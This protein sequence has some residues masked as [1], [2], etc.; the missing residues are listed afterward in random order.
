MSMAETVAIEEA[1]KPAAAWDLM[2]VVAI[3]QAGFPMEL[4]SP[5]GDSASQ[6]EAHV[7][8][9][10][11]DRL[12][13]IIT[14]LK[15]QIKSIEHPAKS[16]I[17][18]ALGTRKPFGN[19]ALA[20]IDE[21]DWRD[22]REALLEYHHSAQKLLDRWKQFEV[23]LASRLNDSR[24]IVVEEFKLKSE[25]RAILMLSNDANYGPFSD[26]L[27][28]FNDPKGGHF[29][30]MADMLTLYLQ[31]VTTKNDT[32][33]HF[34]PINFGRVDHSQKGINWSSQVNLDR[35]SYCSHWAAEQIA[36]M[37]S[38]V[39]D[40]NLHIQPRR[41]PLS[42]CDDGR[43]DLYAFTTADGLMSDWRFARVVSQP[44]APEAQW[45]WERCDGKATI[46]EL[47]HGWDN[48]WITNGTSRASFDEAFEF[49]TKGGFVV[50]HFEIPA[51]V[52]EPLENLLAQLNISNTPSSREVIRKIADLNTKIRTFA[53]C[54]PSE[55]EE[56]LSH[57][58]DEFKSL[59]GCEPN[60]H[61]GIHQADRSVLFEEAHGLLEDLTIG[62][63]ISQFV[64]EELAPAFE[65]T[66]AKSR[67][68]MELELEVLTDWF[69]RRFGSGRQ[70]GLH[71]FYGAFF[72][73]RDHLRG[74]T[75]KVENQL[76]CFDRS[77]TDMLLGSYS[78]SDEEIVVPTIDLRRFVATLPKW[79]AAVCNPDILFAAKSQS[80]LAQGKFLAV[81][82]ECHAIREVLSHSSFA[83]MAEE[84]V[85]EFGREVISGY[86]GLL[87]GDEYLV[88]IIRGHPDKTACQLELPIRDLEVFGRS[89]K[90]RGNVLQPHQVHLILQD[91]G[92]ELRARSIEG[93]I[94]LLAPPAG[95]PSIHDDP[96]SVFAFPRNFSG[97]NVEAGH[98]D[99]IP[100]IRTG[101]VVLHRRTWRI[102]KEQL[103]GI[104][105]RGD[106]VNHGDAAE[107]LS[108]QRLT[109]RLGL[110]RHVFAKVPGEPKP[111][112]VDWL[113]P[114]LVR[115]LFRLARDTAGQIE[116]SEM[117]PGPEHLW[118]DIQGRRYTSELRCAVF[119]R[120]GRN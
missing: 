84:R 92:L 39:P 4:L 45:L 38:S 87:E 99:Y 77:M 96:L 120:K 3:R 80:E 7:L 61:P 119:N 20:A 66:L 112:Y 89:P 9:S 31:R 32:H 116:F 109:A 102:P 24:K 51:G 36:M 28:K 58:K 70:V 22:A 60:R 30:R 104:T 25:L 6:D 82:G 117:L 100:R 105:V 15:L 63:D 50:S 85:P 5:L 10:L 65:L 83:K 17:S 78:A 94:R 107:F 56:R 8:L 111:I 52:H 67:L 113:A 40:L 97:I 27:D 18:N 59:T 14:W 74:E 101:R 19:D 88:E 55:R 53:T 46:G 16:S 91:R 2:P 108:A 81:I 26:W 11:Q 79:P 95:G 103:R 64:S 62:K 49:L 23:S 29:R 118:L 114:L 106:A 72:E 43:L 93:R 73:E 34:G 75:A 98:L 71:Q 54:T 44:V 33:S 12:V 69:A 41:R 48:Q 76:R 13:E 35:R 115:Q 21:P 57:I 110:P 90:P 37:A 68:R 47:R 86:E 1:D 42:F